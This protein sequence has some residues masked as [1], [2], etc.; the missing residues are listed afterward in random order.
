L[1]KARK[2]YGLARMGL[3]PPAVPNIL[4]LKKI[5]SLYGFEGMLIEVQLFLKCLINQ[6]IYRI[7]FFNNQFFYFIL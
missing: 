5:I 1:D 2:K 4:Q 7:F 6:K 3:G